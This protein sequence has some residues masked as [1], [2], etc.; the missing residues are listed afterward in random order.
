MD[1][2]GILV[3]LL[4]L[5]SLAGHFWLL[6][7]AYKE[8]PM[9]ALAIFFLSPIAAL[10]FARKHWA[11]SKNP[12]LV[13]VTS[14][15]LAVALSILMAN[16]FI[17]VELSNVGPQ[18]DLA[19]KEEVLEELVLTKE[20]LENLDTVEGLLVGMSQQSDNEDDQKF[21]RLISEYVLYKKKGFTDRS[22]RYLTRNIRE[23]LLLPGLDTEQRIRLAEVMADLEPEKGKRILTT[24]ASLPSQKDS[25]QIARLTSNEGQP[26]TAPK[27]EKTAALA[28]IEVPEIETEMKQENQ[29]SD[30][31]GHPE[32]ASKKVEQIQREKEVRED[33]SLIKKIS[34]HEA[35]Q[36]IGSQ[37]IFLN[38]VGIEQ[39][40]FL[41]EVSRAGLECEKRFQAGTFSS[42]YSRSEIKSLRVYRN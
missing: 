15:C 8:S 36:Y 9:W 35:K 32:F 6:F 42:Q 29:S 20:A 17:G 21:I 14:F 11:V 30:S 1:F 27:N 25:E 12:F 5:V 4:W 33:R 26:T 3:V 18:A 38:L 41:I 7:F 40:C 22:R 16:S 13:Y 34:F 23:L 28:L 10:V 39:K 2:L 37:V 24:E 19:Q 31:S